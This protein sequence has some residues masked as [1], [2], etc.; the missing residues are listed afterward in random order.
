MTHFLPMKKTQ[1]YAGTRS[2]R[3]L[4]KAPWILR[5]MGTFAIR[6][7]SWFVFL[8]ACLACRGHGDGQETQKARAGDTAV[9]A[10][11]PAGTPGSP[12]G[13]PGSS[14][15][16]G[17]GKKGP[18]GAGDSPRSLEVSAENLSEFLN[19]FV[20]E[21]HPMGSTAQK[22]YTRE[23]AAKLKSWG[24]QVE[25]Q[26]FT[27]DSPNLAH[28]VFG[29]PARAAQKTVKKEGE[30]IVAV[31]EGPDPC[32]L[33]LGGHYDTKF[34]TNKTFVGANDG[35]SSTVLQLELAR[36]LG[37]QK[38]AAS[39]GRWR[40]CTLVN[41][42]FD[43]EEAFAPEWD[44]G[45]RLAGVRDNLYGS[46]VFVENLKRS[47]SKRDA[48]S[49]TNSVDKWH[50]KNK[51]VELVMVIDMV[52]HKNQKLFITQ[53][54]DRTQSEKLL[55][56][57]GSVDIRLD[58]GLIDDDHK[59]FAARGI[60]FVHVIDWTNLAEWHTEKDTKEIIST[61]KLADFGRAILGFL[62]DK[63]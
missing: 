1:T 45:Q 26:T 21:P 30:N 63:R 36:V 9:A 29:G 59:P 56:H 42:W 43:G 49:G 46:H 10:G 8:P 44:D 4:A 57:K 51:P 2:A 60:P 32:V 35:G 19:R 48:K 53:G 20:K 50:F 31:R 40:D 41:V 33:V 22:A 24:W 23:L 13:T 6:R 52:G 11:S 27:T 17:D 5:Q 55:R 47:S 15:G 58:S 61:Q 16:T 25:L 28:E 3:S 18:L 38:N 39:T 7:W 62:D 34:Y 54:S 37:A 14:A 12:A